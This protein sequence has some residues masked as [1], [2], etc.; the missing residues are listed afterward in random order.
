MVPCSTSRARWF[1]LEFLCLTFRL[2]ASK[3]LGLTDTGI[4]LLILSLFL[5]RPSLSFTL[6]FLLFRRSPLSF[7][8]CLCAFLPHRADPS[9][10]SAL[11]DTRFSRWLAFVYRQCC[12]VFSAHGLAFSFDA[13]AALFLIL[14]RAAFLF[15]SCTLLCSLVLIVWFFVGLYIWSC[16]SHKSWFCFQ[17]ETHPIHSFEKL[18]VSMDC[19]FGMMISSIAGSER[20][21]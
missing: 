15:W 5:S 20:S 17:I 10:W 6:A 11:E 3:V 7:L 9:F 1:L 18:S 8:S 13:I 4:S 2:A 14:F 21:Y 16:V 19:S 12:A